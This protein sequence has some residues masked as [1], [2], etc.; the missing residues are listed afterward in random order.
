MSLYQ[1]IVLVPVPVWASEGLGAALAM[2]SPEPGVGH[3]VGPL[4]KSLHLLPTTWGSDGIGGIAEGSY[5]VT[6][7]CGELGEDGVQRKWCWFGK[8]SC[9][10]TNTQ[11]SPRL[12]LQLGTRDQS[13]REVLR[14]CE[15]MTVREGWIKHPKGRCGPCPT[16]ASALIVLGAVSESRVT[17]I[18]LEGEDPTSV[19]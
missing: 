2:L 4:K 3:E 1:T 19:N 6:V 5:I 15:G 14:M 12:C 7:S 17:V 10:G 8:Y 18:C 11:C 9:P 16:L 13:R